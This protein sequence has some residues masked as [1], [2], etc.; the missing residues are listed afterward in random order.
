M[1]PWISSLAVLLL[2]GA[3][4]IRFAAETSSYCHRWPIGPLVI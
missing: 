4:E 3:R 2:A 1:A